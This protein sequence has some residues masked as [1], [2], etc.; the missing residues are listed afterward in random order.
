MNLIK[1][2]VCK[3]VLE[4]YLAKLMIL[5]FAKRQIYKNCFGSFDSEIYDKKHT[6]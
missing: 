6:K 3:K 5:S 1:N 4:V 2:G